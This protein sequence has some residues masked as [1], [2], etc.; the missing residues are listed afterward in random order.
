LEA[1]NN[2]YKTFDP[3]AFKIFDISVHWYGVMYALALI[4]AISIAH[5]IVK[6]DKLKITSD[7]LD[8]YIWW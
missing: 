6:K 2:I 3:V 5:W 8:S 1:W 7:F 4:S